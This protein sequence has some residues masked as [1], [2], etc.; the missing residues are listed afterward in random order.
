MDSVV[1]ESRLVMSEAYICDGVRSPIGRYGGSLAT[2]RPDDL[3]AMV[4]RALR[5]RHPNLPVTAIDDVVLGCANQAGEDNR[6][7]A[8]MA[9]LL[10]GY[11]VGVPGGTVNRLCGSGMYALGLAANSIR[12]QETQVVV[13]GGVESMSRAPFVVGKAETPY[14]RSP[15]MFDTTMGW[16]FINPRMEREY[17]TEPMPKTAENLARIHGISR[18]DQDAFAQTS[19]TRARQAQAMGLFREE[20][21]ELRVPRPRGEHILMTEDEHPR[22]TTYEKLA[23]L[24]SLFEDGTITAGNSSGINDGAA[25]LLL[26]SASAVHTW[27]LSPYARIAGMAVAGVEPSIMGIGPVPATEKILS[28]LG[29]EMSDISIIELNE[30]FAAQ[31]LACS[32]QLGLE[33]D[34][35]RLNP[36]GGAIALGHP[37]G[38][39]GSRLVLSAARQLQRNGGRYALC[40]MCIGVGQGIAMVIERA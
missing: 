2:V 36:Q 34:D 6:N 19:Q 20:I 11:G 30:A 40:A 4:L 26:A 37:L 28:R 7:V 17:G 35:P 39:S 3:A 12:S 13:A 9:S 15:Q 33:D 22:D 16:R 8:R 38:M 32:R 1:S 24:S 10:A 23:S 31:V 29:L 21:V 5:E 14:D 27:G 18:G 25:A